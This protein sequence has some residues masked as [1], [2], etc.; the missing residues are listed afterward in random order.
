VTKTLLAVDDSATMRKALEI[1]FSG[2][3]FKV[4]GAEGRDAATGKLG[5]NPSVV[6]IDTVLGN[7]DGYALCKEVRGKLP[8]AAIILLSSR[9]S[10]YDPARGQEAGADDFCDKPFDTQQLI[11][12]TRKALTLRESGAGLAAGTVPP[13][14]ATATGP[15]SVPMAPPAATPA[16][17]PPL[18]AKAPPAA[19]AAP[20]AKPR[21][22]T[23]MF[24][25]SSGAGHAVGVPP[26]AAPAASPAPPVAAVGLQARSD[27]APTSGAAAPASVRPGANTNANATASPLTPVMGHPSLGGARPA[28]AV[29]TGSFAATPAVSTQPTAVPVQAGGSAA[30]AH[31]AVS[32]AVHSGMAQKLGELGLSREQTEG[33]LALTRDVIERV[34]WEVVPTLAE[35]MIREE[36]ARLTKGA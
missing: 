14:A 36:I 12:K 29:G 2:E 9:Y 6:V 25:A 16:A 24:G 26:S 23:L 33:I 15:V 27:A 21:A 17:P 35:T 31:P 28:A 5:E 19:P 34:V 30:S 20:A 8:K 3:D 18:A 11:D 13:V 22:A 4:L 7:G 10:P 32:A 1:T